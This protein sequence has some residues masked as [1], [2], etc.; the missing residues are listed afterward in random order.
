MKSC[1]QFIFCNN[2]FEKGDKV[3]VGCSGGSD[4]IALLHFL[5]QNQKKFGIEVS[6]IHIDHKIRENSGDD[7]GFVKEF[8]ES[9]GLNFYQFSV[10]VPKLAKE[11]GQSLETEARD[12]RYKVFDALV[13]RGVVNKVALAHHKNDQ[14]ETILMHIFRGSGLAGAKG[15][16]A[17]SGCYVRPMLDTSKEEIIGYLKKNRLKNVEDHTNA[18]NS[19]SRNYLRNVIMKDIV[20]RW[21]GAINSIVNFG[22]SASQDDEYINSQIYQDALIF[23]GKLAKIPTS[24]FV[25]S[26]SIL[27]RIIFKAMNLLGVNKDIERRH[28]ALISKLALNGDNGNKLSLP[29][30]IVA[31]KEYDYIAIHRKQTKTEDFHRAFKSGEFEVE[32]WGRLLV[33]K[34]KREDIK[35]FQNDCLYIDGSLLPKN[36]VWRFRQEGDEFCKFGGGRKKL[37]SFLIDKK[38]PARL[39]DFIP[40]LASDSEILVVA[41]IEIS[42][43]VKIGENSKTI[44][45]IQKIEE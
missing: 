39:R 40:V 30:G 12:A 5:A 22:K 21:P 18:D 17:V 29:F 45:Q 27:A 20:A 31:V 28:I 41:G 23:D 35:D 37:K 7:C 44:Y 25:Y 2:L 3:G 32:G 33:K 13:S 11:N 19:Y 36:A 38:I 4:S 34:V 8:A 43:K 6:V 16:D 26:Q 1:E 42:D 14:A 9:L 10:D 24:Y 15:M